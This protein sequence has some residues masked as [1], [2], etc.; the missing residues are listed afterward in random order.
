MK[1]RKEGRERERRKERATERERERERDRGK[2]WKLGA[3]KHQETVVEG[4]VCLQKEVSLKVQKWMSGSIPSNLPHLPQ[5]TN[6][7]IKK[8]EERKLK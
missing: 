6:K 8:R 5:F 4:D 1:E 7:R 2:F 3:H